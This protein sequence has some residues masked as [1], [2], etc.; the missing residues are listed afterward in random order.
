M[1]KKKKYKYAVVSFTYFRLTIAAV[2]Y[3]IGFKIKCDLLFLY[4]NVPRQQIIFIN[5]IL[6][7]RMHE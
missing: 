2:L 1:K 6:F 7:M 3:G 5:S 4:Y